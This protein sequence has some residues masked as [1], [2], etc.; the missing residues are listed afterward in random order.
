MVMSSEKKPPTRR[1]RADGVE[2]EQFNID[3]VKNAILDAISKKNKIIPWNSP[4]G[5]KSYNIIE[6]K[7]GFVPIEPVF[8]QPEKKIWSVPKNPDKQVTSAKFSLGN[9]HRSLDPAKTRYYK[10]DHKHMTISE[11][12]KKDPAKKKEAKEKP[13]EKKKEQVQTK[14]SK[15]P[16]AKETLEVA[17]TAPPTDPG[18]QR[19]MGFSEEDLQDLQRQVKEQNIV[20]LSKEERENAEERQ[21]I[22][23]KRG[24]KKSVAQIAE[25]ERTK[26]EKIPEMGPYEKYIPHMKFDRLDEYDIIHLAF[27]RPNQHILMPGPTGCGK[28]LLVKQY[29][30]DHDIPRIMV[31]CRNE[32]LDLLGTPHMPEKGVTRFLMGPLPR[33]MELGIPLQLEEIN[34][35]PEEATMPLTSALTEGEIYISQIGKT[36]VAAPG[37]RIIGTYNPD[38]AG[39]FPFNRA[40]FDRFRGGLIEITYLD[41]DKEADRFKKLLHGNPATGKPGMNPKVP[42]TADMLQMLEAMITGIRNLAESKDEAWATSRDVDSFAEWLDS[43]WRTMYNKEYKDASGTTKKYGPPTD[44]ELETIL[45]STLGHTDN[46]TYREEIRQQIKQDFPTV[47]KFWGGTKLPTYKDDIKPAIDRVFLSKGGKFDEE[48]IIKELEGVSGDFVLDWKDIVDKNIEAWTDQYINEM[49]EE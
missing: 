29:M 9:F 14:L 22:L 12:T 25:E 3:S 6:T 27:Q 24:I 39:T 35:L 40:V 17:E 23:L 8:G 16:P 13:P 15:E 7:Y 47:A 43:W 11:I 46:A 26:K 30:H 49:P 10:P 28:S 32:D 37:F 38:Y 2:K 5:T 19:G 33:A 20:H 48:D 4:D 36:V 45:V 31:P 18:A 41:P 21:E 42:V 1:P 34:A 44:K